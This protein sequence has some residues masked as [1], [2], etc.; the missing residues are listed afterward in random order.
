MTLKNISR[1]KKPATVALASCAVTA[2]T[3]SAQS[4]GDEHHDIEEIVVEASVLPRTVEQL[5]Q[6]T[7]VLSGD[8][9]TRKVA[10]S[11]GETLSQELGLS[12][13]YFGPMAST[14]GY[15]WSVRRTRARSQQRP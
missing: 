7:S 5:A 4:T 6:P 10:P 8:E 3:A 15:S 14:T 2:G 11:I 1:W 12:S 9:L 13:T